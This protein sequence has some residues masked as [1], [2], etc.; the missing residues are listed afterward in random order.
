MDIGL[1]IADGVRVRL[2]DKI[3]NIVKLLEEKQV[4]YT[5]PYKGKTGSDINMIMFMESCGVELNIF[6]DVITYI[7]C[8]NSESNYVMQLKNGMQP[9]DALLTIKQ[10]LAREFNVSEGDIRID[11]FDGGSL[12][13]MLSI[14]ITKTHKAKIELVMGAK[15]KIFMHSISITK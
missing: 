6:N 9:I 1:N 10:N 15:Q 5:I 3:E 14:P 13:S 11:R 2:G 4:D 12:N 7:K 8:N